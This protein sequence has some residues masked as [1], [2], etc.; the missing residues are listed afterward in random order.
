VL[1]LFQLL[2]GETCNKLIKP[3]LHDIVNGG[4]ADDGIGDPLTTHTSC[5][6]T[7]K[8]ENRRQKIRVAGGV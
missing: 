4:G 7:K 8:K 6:G 3:H 1:S 5:G 2:A